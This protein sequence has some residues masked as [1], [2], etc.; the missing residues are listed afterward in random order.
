MPQKKEPPLWWTIL[1]LLIIATVLI[2]GTGYILMVVADNQRLADPAVAPVTPG[3]SWGIVVDSPL[4][5][6]R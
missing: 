4:K 3:S 6:K 1:K 2:G 5:P